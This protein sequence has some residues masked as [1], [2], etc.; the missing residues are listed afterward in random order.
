MN[1]CPRKKAGLEMSPGTWKGKGGKEILQV[2]RHGDP[3][4]EI[5]TCSGMRERESFQLELG[6]TSGSVENDVADAGPGLRTEDPE[7]DAKEPPEIRR[8]ENE[9]TLVSGKDEAAPSFVP[10]FIIT[11][12]ETN[13]IY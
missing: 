12:I 8:A 1:Q 4:W 5:G 7:C 11:E 13:S 9:N 3:W 10:C 2:E 6:L